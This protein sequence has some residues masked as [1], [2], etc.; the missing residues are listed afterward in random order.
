MHDSESI[1]RVITEQLEAGKSVVLA[2]IIS[3][4]GSSPRHVGTKMVI[5]EDG[6]NYGTIGGSLL[7]AA[8][9]IEAKNVLLK[10]QSRFMPFEL[11]GK[12][13]TASGMIC[14]GKVMMLLDY[15]V[16]ITENQEF[17]TIWSKVALGGGD[18]YLLTKLKEVEGKVKIDSRAIFLSN[19]TVL[20]QNDFSE[21]DFNSLKQRLSAI[22]NITILRTGDSKI[23]VEPVRNLK[24]VY[25]FGAGH[26]ALP[27]AQ[28]AAQVDFRVV[29]LDNRAEY[30]NVERFPGAS[31]IHVVESFDKAFTDLEIDSD[32]FV[33]IL[34]RGHQYDREVLEQ[35]LKTEA[36]Y[37]GMISSQRKRA[38][39]YQCLMD[40]GIKKEQLEKVHS[41]IGIPIGGETPEEIAVSIIAELISERQKPE[42][43]PV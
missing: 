15:V 6:R 8:V 41:P 39:I 40:N 26:V 22:N 36:G 21:V 4:Q 27:T 3:V 1:S 25:L 34:T 19:G 35:A 9:I 33:V 43:R 5:A 20:G 38:A 14:G 24:T 42:N 23:I 28:I 11:T 31:E 16:P 32:S 30:A 7:E 18:Y 10:K 2:S 17:F 29:V 12:D 37:I 13:A